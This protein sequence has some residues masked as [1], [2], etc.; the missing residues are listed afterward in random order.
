MKSGFVSIIGRPNV[1]KST[2][3]NN[4]AGQKISIISSKPQTTRNNLKGIMTDERGQIVFV[5][6]P[7]LHKPHHLLGE[8]LVKA[9]LESLKD[10]DVVLFLVDGTEIV[11][12]GDKYIIDNFVTKLD[13]PVFL[14]I[15]KIDKVPKKEKSKFLET[16]KALYDFKEIFLISA[17]HGENLDELVN[18]VFENLPEGVPYYDPDYVTDVN[19]REIAGELIREQIFRLLGDEIPHCS[20]VFIESFED[21]KEKNLSK[22]SALIY[23]EKKSQK[24]IVIGKGGLKLK[25]IGTNARLEIEKLVGNKVFLEL[26]VKLLEDWRGNKKNLK[27]LGY[28]FD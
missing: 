15:N 23:V 1:G 11:G 13:K 4:F 27:K 24:G 22:I 10:V 12:G 14:L 19:V 9:A 7:G 2:L 28:I 17:K 3:I 20:A 21:I 16:Y 5:D 26:N 18:K 6:T 8:S 25:E